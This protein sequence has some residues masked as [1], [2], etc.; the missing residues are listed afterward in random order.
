M[1]RTH[2][3]P[4]WFRNPPARLSWPVKR[5]FGCEVGKLP[6]LHK[7]WSNL[8]KRGGSGTLS[9][10]RI[11]LANQFIGAQASGGVIPFNAK[12]AKGSSA[13]PAR[14]GPVRSDPVVPCS[15]NL[16]Q[17]IRHTSIALDQP[18]NKSK[19][20]VVGSDKPNR[21]YLEMDQTVPYCD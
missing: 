9:A 1:Y 3:Y 2:A 20:L 15:S 6:H 5:G 18:S 10:R 12:G 14:R 16:H 7:E 4:Q 11:S 17:W 13:R 8:D 19:W 21:S